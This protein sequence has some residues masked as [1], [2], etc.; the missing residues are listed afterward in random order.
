MLETLKKTWSATRYAQRLFILRMVQSRRR[1]ACFASSILAGVRCLKDVPWSIQR[2]VQRDVA[3]WT[4]FNRY[5]KPSLA[6]PWLHR[7]GRAGQQ[8][9]TRKYARAREAFVRGADIVFLKRSRYA[10]D[11]F[12]NRCDKACRISPNYEAKL[13]RK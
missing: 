10:F 7:K 5:R 11:R 6:V 9:P 4:A 1:L 2:V 3:D 12:A 8:Y 13:H